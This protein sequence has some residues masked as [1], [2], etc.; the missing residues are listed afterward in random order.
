MAKENIVGKL[1]AKS[2]NQKPA[3]VSLKTAAAGLTNSDFLPCPAEKA[4]ESDSVLP[5]AT[6]TG[7][8]PLRNPGIATPG[9]WGWP[10]IATIWAA[11]K[12]ANIRNLVYAALRALPQNPPQNL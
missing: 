12:T 2:L 9:F 6:A 4:L 5:A 8:A 7:G 1:P 10:T 11:A 3:G